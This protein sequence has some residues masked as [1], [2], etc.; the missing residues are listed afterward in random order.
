MGFLSNIIKFFAEYFIFLVGFLFIFVVGFLY[1]Y[2]KP[3][4]I[5]FNIIFLIIAVGWVIFMVKYF[6]ELI[7]KNSKKEEM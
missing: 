3:E 5:V 1:A 6:W 7:D 4:G 2:I